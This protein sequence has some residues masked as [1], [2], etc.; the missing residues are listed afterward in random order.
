MELS[1]IK[2]PA[3][4]TLSFYWNEN[5]MALINYVEQAFV[6]GIKGIVSNADTL[7]ALDATITVT[8]ISATTQSRS[9]LGGIYYRLL[10]PGTSYT[11]TATATNYVSQTKQVTLPANQDRVEIVNFALK[12]VSTTSNNSTTNNATRPVPPNNSTQPIIINTNNCSTNNR[13]SNS[14]AIAFM[15]LLVTI[16]L[17]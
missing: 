15:A 2:Y 5:K 11:I 17:I 14:L 3:A 10:V 16:F 12:S 8:G 13:W 9:A 4:S 7:E 6:I 1:D